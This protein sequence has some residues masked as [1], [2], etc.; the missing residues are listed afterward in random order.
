MLLIAKQSVTDIRNYDFAISRL[1][2][3]VKAYRAKTV[4]RLAA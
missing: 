3:A 4:E 1:F 2:W